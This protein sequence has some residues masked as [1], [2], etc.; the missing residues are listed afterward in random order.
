MASGNLN[1]STTG[2][3]GTE[4]RDDG[5][6]PVLLAHRLRLVVTDGPDRGLERELLGTRMSVGTS[7]QNDLVLSDTTVSRRHAELQVDGDRYVIRDLGSTNGTAVNDTPVVEAYL[8][9]GARVQLGG[10]SVLFE[11]KKKWER[12]S[13]SEEDHFGDLYGN[14]GPM[15]EV[16]SMLQKLS[17]SDLSC[18]LVGETGTGKELAAR[19]IHAHSPRAQK[20]FVV[21]DCGAV[22]SNLIESELFGHEKGAFTGA[23]RQRPGAFEVADGGTIFLDEI[24]ELPLELQPKLL[25]ALERREVKRLGATKP[26]EVN[27]RIIAA[28]HR[29]LPTLIQEGNFR[30]DLYYRLAEVVASL[31]PLRDRPDDI[32]LLAPR[33]VEEQTRDSSPKSLSDDALKLLKERSWP[34]NV[35]ELRNVL[36]R[37]VALCPSAT[38]RRA[39]LEWMLDDSP[40]PE[41]A[42]SS[43][44]GVPTPEIGEELPIREAREQ[45]VAPMEREY[46]VR[47]M[48]RCGGNIDRASEEAG[49][50]RKSLERLLRQHG[51][52]ASELAGE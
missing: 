8:T 16:F 5:A 50:H 41:P 48:R 27:V 52:K 30:E 3:G 13:E 29:D 44:S 36:R 7:T 24:G 12:V 20:R 22:T 31:P 51:L 10:T 9:P 19:A 25:R 33:M 49:V 47:L 40:R 43:A 18:V 21:V 37:A 38:I 6:G 4:V 34:G 17:P 2:L 45:W 15:R 1:T 28:T 35:R 14:S 32:A 11:P 42:S 26:I 46:L 39:D 23:D